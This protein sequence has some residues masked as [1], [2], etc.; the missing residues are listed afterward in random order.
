MKKR[1]AIFDIDGTVFRSSLIIELV[2]SLTSAS[3]FPKNARAGYEKEFSKW[4]NRRGSYNKYISG[5]VDVFMRNIKG[6]HYKDFLNV[7]EL[8]IDE[9]KERVYKYTRDLI[10]KLKKDKYYLLAVSQSPKT[11]LDPFCK[12]MG[13]DKIYGRIY[14][15][16]PQ[17]RFTGAIIDRHLIENKAGILRR[18]IEKENLTLDRSIGVGDT[19]NDIP[20]LELVETPICFNPDSKLERYA[21][22]NNWKIVVERKDVIYEIE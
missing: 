5:V 20:F 11:I 13:F 18:A 21:R 1:V 17:N 3:I 19:E 4:L 15:L 10:K 16:G 9:H 2:D 6:V 7:S 14:E 22:L 8:V 12:Y